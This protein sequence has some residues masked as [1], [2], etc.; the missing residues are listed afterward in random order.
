MKALDVRFARHAAAAAWMKDAGSVIV[1]VSGGVDSMTLLHLLRFREGPPRIGLHAAHVDHRMREGSGEDAA[2]LEGICAEWDVPFHLERAP[3]PVASEAEGRRLR[4]RFFEE[5]RGRL[6]GGAVTMTAHT[7]DDQ[8]ET[9]LFR[10][11]RGSGP[12]GLGG[13]R[14]ERFPHVV[15]PLLPF[16][17]AEIEAFA[18]EQG[19]P[20]RDDPTN[21]DPRWTRNRIRHA[22]L[23]ALEQAVPGASAAL[24]AL[25]DTS[26][27]EGAALE[28]LLDERIAV[29]SRP[30]PGPS[31]APEAA[32]DTTS[33]S[34]F[35][36]DRRALGALSPPLL[37]LVL[38]RAAQRLGGDPGR[39][40]T[41]ALVSL[42]RDLPSGRRVDAGG[43]IVVENR[44]GIVAIRCCA[45]RAR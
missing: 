34:G 32:P 6:G 29:L 37:T 26:R 36:L 7:A 13:I 14:A 3:A 44:S 23:P 45:L 1:G 10:A 17:R 30:G 39:A 21:L 28:E 16:R 20:F 2:W 31:G 42:V 40:A 11:A 35:L 12:R 27:L 41:A 33:P 9:V 18:G 38:R 25:A 19:I 43:G 8:A 5:V 15:R 22:V 4:Y 24:A